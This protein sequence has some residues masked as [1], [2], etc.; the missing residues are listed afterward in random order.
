M[1][2]IANKIPV[3]CPK[4]GKSFKE[5]V[6]K[7]RGGSRLSCAYCATAIVFDPQSENLAI[8]RV[9]AAARRYRLAAGTR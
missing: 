2:S 3:S 8:R 9:L 5:S 4:C 6:H 7:I 1:T